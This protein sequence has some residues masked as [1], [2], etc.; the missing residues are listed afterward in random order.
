MILTHHYQDTPR[1]T[2]DVLNARTVVE[3]GFSGL[4]RS[5]A[6]QVSLTGRIYCRNDSFPS[7]PSLK[8]GVLGKINDF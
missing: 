8:S 3:A 5:V 2:N 4:R 7:P 1:I 6:I